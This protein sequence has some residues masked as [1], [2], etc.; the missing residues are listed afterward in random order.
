MQVGVLDQFIVMYVLFDF[1]IEKG[2]LIFQLFFG[3][4][5]FELGMYLCQ[6]NCWFDWFGDVICG[7][8][9]EVVFFIYS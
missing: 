6:N 2:V 7:V 3:V 8:E 9:F 5:I 4:F 1:G